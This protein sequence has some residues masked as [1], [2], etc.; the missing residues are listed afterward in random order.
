MKV[1][2]LLLTQVVYLLVLSCA[3]SICSAQ[4]RIKVQPSQGPVALDGLLTEPCWEEAPAISDFRQRDPRE[5]DPATEK[6]AIRV[7]YPKYGLLQKSFI[8]AIFTNVQ[9][10]QKALVKVLRTGLQTRWLLLIRLF[11]QT[12]RCCAPTSRSGGPSGPTR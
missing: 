8:G 3:A 10:C 12:T 1:K 4:D 2:S 11:Q 5:G 6:T 7:V 9:S